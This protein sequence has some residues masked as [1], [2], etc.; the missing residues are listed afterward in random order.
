MGAIERNKP[1]K[2]RRNRIGISLE[3]DYE[4]K[5]NRLSIACGNM[6]PTTLAYLFV[7]HCLDDPNVIDLFQMDYKTTDDY[8]I[9]PVRDFRGGLDYQLMRGF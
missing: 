1:G 9:I 2:G 8:R 4:K 7:R 6:A 3:T 5:L